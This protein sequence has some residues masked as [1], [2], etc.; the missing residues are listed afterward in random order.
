MSNF[1]KV[2]EF[3]RI[4]DKSTPKDFQELLNLRKSLMSEELH[5]VLKAINALSSEPTSLKHRAN[6]LKELSDLLY[7]VYGTACSIG[8]DADAA[9]TAVHDSNMSKVGNDGKPIYREDG[10]VLKGPNYHKPDLLKFVKNE[11]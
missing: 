7:V 1:K 4:F 10:K 6:L 11:I 3:H 2:E 5:E 8:W 9:F